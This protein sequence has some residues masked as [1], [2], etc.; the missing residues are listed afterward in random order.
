MHVCGPRQRCR[1]A[2]NVC[3]LRRLQL[4]LLLWLE[5]TM[6]VEVALEQRPQHPHICTPK[7]TRERKR[8]Y[9]Q[10]KK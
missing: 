1:C 7:A 8:A 6:G 2:K 4:E 3:G 5:V 10:E 9:F